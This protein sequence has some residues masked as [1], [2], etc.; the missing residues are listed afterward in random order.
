MFYFI[1]FT[2]IYIFGSLSVINFNQI[3]EADA[4]RCSVK[5]VF[6]K[7]LPNLQENIC[8]SVFFDKVASWKLKACNFIKKETS[9]QMFSH[10]FQQNFSRL[11]SYLLLVHKKNYSYLTDSQY[12]TWLSKKYFRLHLSQS[13]HQQVICETSNFF[14]WLIFLVS[15]SSSLTTL[16][17]PHSLLINSL[18]FQCHLY[19]NGLVL[20]QL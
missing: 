4:R 18:S 2:H 20:P 5:R 6:L 8:I 13:E 7:I 15:S 11:L 14:F 19:Q 12:Y 9:T 10:E 17:F 16:R 3:A 1:G